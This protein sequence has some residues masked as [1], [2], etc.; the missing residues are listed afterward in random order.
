MREREG[1]EMAGSGGEYGA[2]GGRWS[3]WGEWG[4]KEQMGWMEAGSNLLRKYRWTLIASHPKHITSS[5]PLHSTLGLL[6]FTPSP[7]HHL[8]HTI[9][10][11]SSHSLHRTPES[12]YAGKVTF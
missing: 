12:L 4:Q 1:M 7:A 11:T 6:S 5:P 2:D 3:K 9:S 10:F 8:L